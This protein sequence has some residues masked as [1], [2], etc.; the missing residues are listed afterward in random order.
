MRPRKS[1]R[2]AALL[3]AALAASKTRRGSPSEPHARREGACEQHSQQPHHQ[4][5]PAHHATFAAPRGTGRG[6]EAQPRTSYQPMAR[7]G[8][9]DSPDRPEKTELVSD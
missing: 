6:K 5:E 8:S 1:P 9:V 3:P 2:R 4:E 7:P